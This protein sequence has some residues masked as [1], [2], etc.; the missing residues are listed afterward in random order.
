MSKRHQASRRRT[1]GRRQH[2]LRERRDRVW[3]DGTVDRDLAEDGLAPVEG[4]VAER[5]GLPYG[6]IWLG[7]E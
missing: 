1:Y 6:S 3:Q 2:E 7:L 4:A 5:H